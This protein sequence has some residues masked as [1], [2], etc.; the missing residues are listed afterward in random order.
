MIEIVP[1]QLYDEDYLR[2]HL[3]FTEKALANARR[4]EGLRCKRV[5]RRRLYLGQWL[6]DWL[7]QPAPAEG[8]R[9]D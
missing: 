3:H 4:S 2:T 6:L 1:G 7:S 8:G 9:R 5:G